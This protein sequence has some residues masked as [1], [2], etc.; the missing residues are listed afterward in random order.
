MSVRLAV[1]VTSRGG[2]SF[3]PRCLESIR[4]QQEVVAT[5]IVYVDDAS[6]Y[7]HGERRRLR[8]LV[9]TAAGTL[10]CNEK[11][12][13]QVGSIARAMARINDPGAIV[14]L[15]DGDDWLLPH[16]FRTVAKAYGDPQIAM[17][18]GNTL[19]D[20]R[21]FQDPQ[22]SYFGPD[23]RTVN[24]PYADEIWNHRLF[25]QDGFRCFHLRTFRRWL[26]DF[27]HPKDLSLP[28]G[29]PFRGSGDSALMFPMLELL[30]DPKH[31]C[32]ID[33]P[34]YVYRLHGDQVHHLDKAGQREGLEALRSRMPPYAPLNRGLLASLLREN[35]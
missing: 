13:W 12:R 29:E 2:L 32:F 33:E 30:A 20:F 25:R 4:W 24:T 16:A 9:D 10:L 3:A 8:D 1:V 22:S 15:V 18:W 35:R 14:C 27:I 26:W 19:V 34:I 31:A 5:Q 23:K 21:P 7:T 28:S 6:D 11:R 17:T